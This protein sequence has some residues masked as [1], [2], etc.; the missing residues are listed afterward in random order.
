MAT[1]ERPGDTDADA[2]ARVVDA[3]HGAHLPIDQ[4]RH[5]NAPTSPL[6]RFVTRY[7]ER[8]RK[9]WSRGTDRSALTIDEV[10]PAR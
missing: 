3:Y 7:P 1:S 4:D 5:A 8:A 2:I 9:V 6:A 10:E